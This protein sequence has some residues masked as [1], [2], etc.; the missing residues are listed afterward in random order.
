MRD[1]T[2]GGAYLTRNDVPQLGND[3]IDGQPFSEIAQ[4]K[5]VGGT[6]PATDEIGFNAYDS[7]GAYNLPSAVAIVT[8]G[9]TNHPP[10][11]TGPSVLDVEVNQVLQGHELFGAVSDP[12][13]ALDLD[14][15]VFWDATPG[16]GYLALD[17]V[18]TTKAD[19]LVTEHSR[20]T[21]VTGDTPGS[22]DIVVEAFD[23]QGAD[24]NDL[25]VTINVVADTPPPV[26]PN[27]IRFKDASVQIEEGDGRTFL[28]LPVE[29]PGS[30]GSVIVDWE[31][32]AAG[33]HPVDRNDFNFGGG[34]PFGS[35]LIQP[36]MIGSE[37]IRIEIAGDETLEP[38]ETFEVRLVATDKGS[39]DPAYDTV[40]VTILNDDNT[41]PNQKP[42]ANSDEASVESGSTIVIDVLSNDYDPDGTLDKTTLSIVSAPLHG[43]AIIND[44]K[45]KYNSSGNFVGTDNFR[46]G[47]ADDKG[48]GAFAE[49]TV[50][51]TE[52][53]VSYLVSP[54]SADR[55]EGNSGLS[56]FTFLVRKVE[57]MARASSVNYSVVVGS[58][59]GHADADD[60]GGVLPSGIVEFAAE[61]TQ[62]TL[63]IPVS[64]DTLFEPSEAF[65]VSIVFPGGVAEANGFIRNDDTDTS[66]STTPTAGADTLTG[67]SGNDAFDGL[68]G[69]DS[70]DG[71]AGNDTLSGG[72]GA[73]LLYGNFGD[74]VFNLSNDG[75]WG[76]LAAIN[77]HMV[78]SAGVPDQRTITGR[79]ASQDALDGGDGTDSVYGTAGNDVLFYTDVNQP[80]HAAAN[81]S[82]RLASIEYFDLGGGDDVLDMTNASG[83]YPTS[84]TALGGDGADA[85]WGGLGDDTL[86]G[87]A[88]DKDFL[89]GGPGNDRLTGGSGKDI[90]GFSRN[91]GSDVV[92]DFE[93][94]QDNI[95]LKGFGAAYDTYAEVRAAIVQQGADAVLT[96]A[97]A[98][99]STVTVTFLNTDVSV[100][101]ASDFTIIA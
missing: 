81:A 89:T 7:K 17:G 43:T 34:L 72:T 74:D 68:A 97:P 48:V 31:V 100:F 1:R 23:K 79:V 38:D 15:L 6:A 47:I 93:N 10:E 21:Y 24:S 75:S 3:T 54:L 85:L 71:G 2:P 13:G 12:D 96:L 45:V 95:R 20:V 90:F 40:G 49:V 87:G 11:V 69:D 32:V 35:Q 44:G 37:K 36:A 60:F 86:D 55:D 61:E 18:K 59:A 64:G 80:A 14:R 101:D 91:F 65:T 52:P 5:V 92:T 8:T 58:G 30:L 50:A 76:S 78:S 56:D 22:N 99:Q 26:D 42:I 29:V 77:R 41:V 19:V 82:A 27:L 66:P 84:F 33:T 46:Y 53:S 73:D 25:L 9:Q 67:T 4:W 83:G 70:I 51:V 39:I 63:P 98:G 94:G 88:G 57:G 16:A 28:R 62:K